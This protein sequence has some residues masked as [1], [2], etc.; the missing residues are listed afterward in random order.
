M[1]MLSKVRS[2]VQLTALIV[3]IA[4]GMSTLTRFWLVIL[5]LSILIGPVF[6]G[7]MCP[8]GFVQDIAARIRSFLKIKPIKVSDK[9]NDI[10]KYSRYLIY[11]VSLTGLGF[12][13]V[14]LSILD[15][16]STM[17][18]LI[19]FKSIQIISLVALCLF[20]LMSLFIDRFFCRFFCINGAQYSLLSIGRLF[21]IT[22]NDK[23]VKCKKCERNCAMAIKITKR[24]EIND[25]NCIRCHECIGACPVK[26]ALQPDFKPKIIKIFLV[27]IL[28]FATIRMNHTSAASEAVDMSKYPEDVVVV[29][30]SGEGYK[31]QVDVSVVFYKDE[32][33]DVVVTSHTDTTNYMESAKSVIEEMIEN[34]SSEVAI[35]SG[36]TYSSKGIKEAVKEAVRIYENDKK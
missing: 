18:T 9:L 1:K 23:C 33:L 26:G 16:F 13:V 3:F 28:T 27:L 14:K 5:V 8:F 25:L 10:L 6:C 2:L 36:A 30:S 19:T 34:N 17:Q 12:L 15:P 24:K 7:W 35:V 4:I 29:E 21:T 11:L 22:R 31:G 20:T 32:I